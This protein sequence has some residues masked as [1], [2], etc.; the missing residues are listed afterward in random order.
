M[1]K[2]P[3][4][5]KMG[6]QILEAS[7]QSAL[8]SAPLQPNINH[9]GTVFGGSL[10]SV[11]ALACYVLFQEIAREAGGLSDDLV[12]QE[13]RI[14]YLA[15]VKG[16]FQVRAT[17]EEDQSVERFMSALRRS[18]KARLGLR[19]SVLFEGRECAVFEGTYVFHLEPRE[20]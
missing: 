5:E 10:Y 13:G 2:I 7:S 14:Q 17:L 16:D 11:C 18:G 20:S 15:P 12:I 8:L 3:L 9:I 1:Q 19:A 4:S 6:I